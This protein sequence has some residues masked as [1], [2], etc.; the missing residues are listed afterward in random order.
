MGTT[1][2]APTTQEILVH[3]KGVS[4]PDLLSY[5]KLRP[6][7]NQ[8]VSQCSRKAVVTEDPDSKKSTSFTSMVGSPG[9]IYQP[10]WVVTN[11]FHLNTPAACQ[12][13]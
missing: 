8:D 12:D 10:G 6:A 7:P 3:T 11:N 5:V 13:K 1:V 9:S 4:D 2:S